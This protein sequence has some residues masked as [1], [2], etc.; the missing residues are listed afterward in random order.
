MA[1]RAYEVLK[2]EGFSRSEFI[3]VNDEPYLLEM[4]TTP[5]PDHRKYFAGTG[6]GRR[7]IAFGTI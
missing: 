6:K 7:N 5:R 2:M 1:K 4:N 3:F